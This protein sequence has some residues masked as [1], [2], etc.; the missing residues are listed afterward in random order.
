MSETKTVPVEPTEEMIVAAQRNCGLSGP[1]LRSI[2]TD[3]IEAAPAPDELVR[4]C[5]WHKQNIG[6]WDEYD[7]WGT[8]CGE[9]FAIVEEWHEQLPNYCNHCGGKIRLREKENE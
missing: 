1:T 2:Y 9:D 7:S 4:E 6:G 5:L 3:I 8:S